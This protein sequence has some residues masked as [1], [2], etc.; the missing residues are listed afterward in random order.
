MLTIEAIGSDIIETVSAKPRRKL[1]ID[2]D[3]SPT[4]HFSGPSLTS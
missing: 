1:W 3:N 2:L 4:C